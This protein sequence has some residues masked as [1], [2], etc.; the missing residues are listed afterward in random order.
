MDQYTEYLESRG[1]EIS[2]EDDHYLEE[3]MAVAASFRTFDAALDD[4]MADHGYTGA[5]TD[6]E[7]KLD[8]LRCRFTENGVTPLPRNMKKWFTEHRSIERSTAFQLCFAF[9]LD[10]PQTQ[11]FF[12]RVCLDRGFDCHDI[13][14]A[15]CYYCLRRGRSYA[16]AQA[17]IARSPIGGGPLP[18][19]RL[20]LDRD[21]LFTG[22]IISELDRF[23]DDEALL[24]YFEKN[25]QHFRYNHATAHRCITQLWENIAAPEGLANRERQELLGI[26]TAAH[27]SVADLFWQMMGLDERD[28]EGHH[29]YVLH[30]DR[31]LK[32]ILKDNLLLHHLAEADFPDRLSIEEILSGKHKSSEKIRKTLIFLLFYKFWTAAALR[33]QDASYH[34]CGGDADRCIDTIDRYLLECGYPALY[35]G[36]PFDWLF[37]F[38][39]EDEYPLATLRDFIHELYLYKAEHPQR[40]DKSNP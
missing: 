38:A 2:P 16:D 26:K 23:T 39:A 40:T 20:H 34:A 12:R 8:F 13:R 4:F 15:I 35:Y 24:A 14:E 10:V 28:E 9:R 18:R 1:H 29:L 22:S 7:A 11:D 31:S 25:L 30:S 19:T 5:L 37:L 17:L 21:V 36:N 6:L 33:H 32:P 27:R 3:L